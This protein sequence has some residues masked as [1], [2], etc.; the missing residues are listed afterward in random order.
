MIVIEDYEGGITK[1]ESM[2][3]IGTRICLKKANKK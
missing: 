2:L 3:E 1:N